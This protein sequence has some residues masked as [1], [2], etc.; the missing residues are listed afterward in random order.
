M[1]RDVEQKCP[2]CGQTL[3]EHGHRI[4]PG[5]VGALRKFKQGVLDHGRNEIHLSHDLKGP[6]E[7]THTEHANFQK[8]R[9]HG[10]VAKVFDKKGN[11]L[12]GF[13]LLT[14]NGNRFLKGELAIPK[15]VYTISN[16]VSRH[17]AD[18]V[19]IRDVIGS[20]PVFEDINDIETTLL[21]V[22]TMTPKAAARVMGKRAAEVQAERRAADQEIIKTQS[23]DKPLNAHDLLLLR[24]REPKKRPPKISPGQQ[25]L[26]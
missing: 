10:L 16:E 25:P 9:F 13:W 20:E 11:R 5:L 3:K 22:G 8:L 14:T 4:T 21:P 7:L 12:Q 15:K 6:L 26:I 18:L 1:S 19:T 23:L 17:S 2:T 24:K